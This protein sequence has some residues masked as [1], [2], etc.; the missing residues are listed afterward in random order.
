MIKRSHTPQHSPLSPSLSSSHLSPLT[1]DSHEELHAHDQWQIEIEKDIALPLSGTKQVTQELYLFLPTALQISHHTYPKE[2]FYVDRVHLFRFKTPKITL[3]ELLHRGEPRSPFTVIEQ[4]LHK[5]RPKL[6]PVNGQRMEEDLLEKH[7]L[8]EFQLSANIIRSQLRAQLELIHTEES[9]QQLLH[10]LD[11]AL[12]RF[13]E[14]F[15]SALMLP[16]HLLHHQLPFVQEGLS[17]S[18]EERLLQLA[19]KVESRPQVSKA[20]GSVSPETISHETISKEM[21]A[22]LLQRAA[23]EKKFL[24]DN[25]HEP[26]DLTKL[27]E[28]EQEL[29]LYRRNLLT[30]FLLSPFLL[31]LKTTFQGYGELIASM[32]AGLAMMFYLLF[33]FWRGAL[34]ID[35]LQ[36]VVITSLLYVLKDRLKDGMKSLLHKQA[37]R[38]FDDQQYDILTDDGK[39]IGKLGEHFQLIPQCQVSE[40]ILRTRFG[41]E[42]RDEVAGFIPRP[43]VV[44][45]YKKQLKLSHHKKQNIGF[46]DRHLD[47]HSIFRLNLQQFLQK[48][49]DPLEPVHTFDMQKNRPELLFLPKIYHLNV[50]VKSVESVGNQQSTNIER[51]KIIADKYCIK[52][53]LS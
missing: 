16:S 30:K 41:V 11:Q 7:L 52:R 18:V 40:D 15:Q 23:Q 24:V 8:E 53:I 20:E 13:N 35:S 47:I 32:A 19:A 31:N 1:L 25:F 29:F 2:R 5:D 10:L 12:A 42:S 28:S 37:R 22:L 9:I 38:L 51:Y 48:A 17:R 4:L 46:C 39:K 26:E 44:L 27:P 49:S 14:L 6:Q 3:H 21:I 43:E 36:L 33:F 34:L 50:V 45:Y